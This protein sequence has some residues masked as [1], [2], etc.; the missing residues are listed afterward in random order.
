MNAFTGM[1]PLDGIHFHDVEKNA[2]IV[3]DMKLYQEHLTKTFINQEQENE[4][5]SNSYN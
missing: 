4:C 1:T 5:L 3:N 2:D